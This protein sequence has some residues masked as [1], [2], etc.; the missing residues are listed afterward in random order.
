MTDDAVEELIAAARQAQRRA[1][2]PYSGF[3]VG[4]ALRTA[5]GRVYRGANVENAAFSPTVCA[6]RVAVPAAV[7][8]GERSFTLLAVVGD[9]PGP[10]APCGVCRQ[11]LFEFAPKLEVI[12][13]GADG[14]RARW[15][16]DTDLLPSAFGP[17][18]LKPP[19]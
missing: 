15:R 12:G 2:A 16:L 18:N 7:L 5:S 17:Q 4:C 19:T 14:V 3:R 6:E 10:C 13:V 11:V 8:D 9:G 1:Y